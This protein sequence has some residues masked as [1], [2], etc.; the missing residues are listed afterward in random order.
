MLTEQIR[1][2]IREEEEERDY[3]SDE[4]RK[5]SMDGQPKIN[6][7]QEQI[8]ADDDGAPSNENPYAAEL[9]SDSRAPDKGE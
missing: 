6:T 2:E 4:E 9:H 8:L 3:R 1:E 5:V 7:Y